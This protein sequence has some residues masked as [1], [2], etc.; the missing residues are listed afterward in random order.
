MKKGK[1]YVL[2]SFSLELIASSKFF[3]KL[4]KSSFLFGSISTW[5]VADKLG[6]PNSLS[7]IFN[8]CKKGNFLNLYSFWFLEIEDN[9]NLF[10][11]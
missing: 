4:W 9:T 2:P 6:V 7:A 8:V 10:D 11:N 1:L 5:G 3:K